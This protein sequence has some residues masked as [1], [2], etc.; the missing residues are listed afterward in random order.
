MLII[1]LK[2]KRFDSEW[3]QKISQVWKKYGF[4]RL[5]FV[6]LYKVNVKNIIHS[7]KQSQIHHLKNL[8]VVRIC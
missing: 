5:N 4:I 6:S 8:L 1:E 3:T 2:R 7:F